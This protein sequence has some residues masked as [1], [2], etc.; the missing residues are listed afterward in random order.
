MTIDRNKPR[1]RSKEKDEEQETKTCGQCDQ[2][3]RKSLSYVQS[4]E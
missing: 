4:L 1:K 2:C 3:L